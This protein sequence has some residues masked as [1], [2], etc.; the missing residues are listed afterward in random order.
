MHIFGKVQ[1]MPGNAEL[2]EIGLISIA[3]IIAR[4]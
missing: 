3:Y 4:K 1:N 2:S